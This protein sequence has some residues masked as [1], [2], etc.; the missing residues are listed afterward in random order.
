MKP[1]TAMTKPIIRCSSLDRLLSCPGSL[2]LEAAANKLV[3]IF[4]DEVDGNAM[5]WRGNWCHHR[6]AKRLVD[7][8]GAIAPEGGLPPPVLPATWKPSPWDFRTAE[9]YVSNL[10]ATIPED[11][12]IFVEHEFRREFPRFILAGHIDEYDINAA[13]TLFSL[14]DLKTGMADVDIADEN[15]QIAGYT[16][17]LHDRYPSLERG[18][19]RIWQKTA[20]ASMTEAEITDLPAVAR[21]IEAKINEALD[22]LLLLQTGQKQCANCD[23][24]LFCPCLNKEIEFMKLTLTPEKLKDLITNPSLAEHGDLAA[25]ARAIQGPLKR[26]IDDFKERLEAAGGKV[27]LSEGVTAELVPTL[28]DRELSSVEVAMKF[29]DEKLGHD[30]TLR[31]LSMSLSKLEDELVATGMKRTSKKEQSASSWIKDT[32]GHLITRQPTKT[33]KFY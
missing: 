12:A 27:E 23:A 17:L 29:T 28:G 7:E 6:S 10:A 15:W 33:L 9:W 26:I 8:F 5:T 4:S 22:N 25:R 13:K 30:A 18:V 21:L 24:I 16:T 19:A 1:Q 32:I 3:T 20:T 31:T 11:H 2:T 14:N